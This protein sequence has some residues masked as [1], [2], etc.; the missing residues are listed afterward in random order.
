MCCRDFVE[1]P[2]PAPNNPNIKI[3]S[4]SSPFKEKPCED[5][6]KCPKP[7]IFFRDGVKSVDFVLV[8]D[9]FAEHAITEEAYDKRRVF[10]SNLVKEGLEIEHEPQ[11][12]NGLN[13]VKVK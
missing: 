12:Q 7:T 3:V 13:F 2:K 1:M 5:P 10:E 4:N 6:V 8:W 9:G 11:E